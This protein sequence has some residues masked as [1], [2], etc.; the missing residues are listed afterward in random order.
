MVDK[1]SVRGV[2]E[3]PTTVLDEFEAY[4]ADGV[5]FYTLGFIQTR[6]NRKSQTV[7][8]LLALFSRRNCRIKLTLAEMPSKAIGVWIHDEV[9]IHDS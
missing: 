5:F 6:R 9:S 4:F 1:K 3:N 7:F 2:L 8:V